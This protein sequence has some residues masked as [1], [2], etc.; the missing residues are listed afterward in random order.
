VL[1][2]SALWS[3]ALAMCVGLRVADER[4]H[5]SGYSRSQEAPKARFAKFRALDAVARVLPLSPVRK[6]LL[7]KDVKIFLRDVSQWSQYSCCSH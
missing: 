6:Q 5:F 7:V 2:A 3:T 4:W 1:H